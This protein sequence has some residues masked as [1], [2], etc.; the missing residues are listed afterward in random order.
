MS[1]LQPGDVADLHV[2]DRYNRMA[3]LVWWLTSQ[4]EHINLRDS[5]TSS[6]STAG[7]TS[8]IH[9][10]LKRKSQC[11]WPAIGSEQKNRHDLILKDS[12]CKRGKDGI[13]LQVR[14]LHIGMAKQV[15][16]CELGMLPAPH[17]QPG[18][19]RWRCIVDCPSQG[20][21]NT[22]SAEQVTV[23]SP[24]CSLCHLF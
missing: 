20:D 3:G 13:Q 21:T 18:K 14:H 10:L 2:Q 5:H 16:L 23:L 24:D 8:K 12:L 4:L 1:V 22:W 11:P 19:H 7:I 17:Q 15:C 9:D 6:G